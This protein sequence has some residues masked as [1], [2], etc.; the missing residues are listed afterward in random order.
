MAQG[1][2]PNLGRERQEA[3]SP[4]P[5]ETPLRNYYMTTRLYDHTTIRPY[6][7]TTIQLHYYH[8]NLLHY[9]TTQVV[10]P[11]VFGQLYLQGRRVGAPQ[12]PMA[13]GLFIGVAA[14]LMLP[15]AFPRP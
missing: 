2:S 9:S 8:A 4:T 11:L 10:G 6:D 13:L 14:T 5:S 1:R 3:A 15:I 7:H 12:L